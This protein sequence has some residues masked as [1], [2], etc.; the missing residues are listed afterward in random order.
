MSKWC[1]I[2]FVSHYVDRNN[3]LVLPADL[4]C[5]ILLIERPDWSKNLSDFKNRSLNKRN[6][7]KKS[8]YAF[9]IEYVADAL[10]SPDPQWK[11]DKPRSIQ[12]IA[13]EKTSLA[14]LSIWLAKPSRL[15][16][17]VVMHFDEID[18]SPCM[19]KSVSFD[20]ILH[21]PHHL[22]NQISMEDISLARQ[23]N[24]SLNSIKRGMTLWTSINLHYKALQESMW[25]VRY[26][27]NWIAM[28]ALLRF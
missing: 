17:N 9:Y 24:I 15:S 13:F 3:Q 21:H 8:K 5:D 18:E 11:G 7:I 12:D 25:E 16:I 1:T 2:G 19:R 27:L 14:C 10:G 22:R 28:E 20:G 6:R 23:L 4:G 26:L